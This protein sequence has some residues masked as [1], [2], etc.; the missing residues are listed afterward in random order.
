MDATCDGL[1]AMCPQLVGHVLH[2]KLHTQESR[3]FACLA[4]GKVMLTE[5]YQVFNS[6]QELSC[7]FGESGKVSLA[8]I[9]ISPAATSP[10]LQHVFYE[11]SNNKDNFS[12]NKVMEAFKKEPKK[13][14]QTEPRRTDPLAERTSPAES[15]QTVKTFAETTQSTGTEVQKIEQVATFGNANQTPL[16]QPSKLRQN[17]NYGPT[18]P[19]NEQELALYA[20]LEVAFDGNSQQAYRAHNENNERTLAVA[21][22][23][24]Q[25]FPDHLPISATA[26]RNY[27]NRARSKQ[28]RHIGRVKNQWR[29]SFFNEEVRSV[30]V[31]HEQ[32]QS[33]M[34]NSPDT[35]EGKT[36][37]YILATLHTAVERAVER[38][39]GNKMSIKALHQKWPSMQARFPNWD[40]TTNGLRTAITCVY[41]EPSANAPSREINM[42][43]SMQWSISAVGRTCNVDWLDTSPTCSSV[44]DFCKLLTS[45]QE[46]HVCDGCNYTKYANVAR[47]SGEKMVRK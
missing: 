37:Q 19:P 12:I 4:Q 28:N 22:A 42:D 6:F 20:L 34:D 24:Y 5:T 25:L 15:N 33:L 14:N 41:T 23:L 8:H 46:S 39:S 3:P 10:T 43:T 7:T 27:F 9:Y 30:Q 18:T 2:W 44:A 26:I 36:S 32:L 38:Y 13:Q 11:L 47:S 17:I 16:A 45:V 31:L 40:M 35:G 1:L 29:W 21:K